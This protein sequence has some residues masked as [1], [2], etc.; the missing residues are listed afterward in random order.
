MKIVTVLRT[1]ETYNRKY[2]EML[3][4]QCQQFA[5]GIE[6]ICISDD[7]LVPG[8][9]KMQHDWPRW[10]PKIE[11]FKIP[12]PVLYL[13]LDTTLVKDI[14]NV[15]EAANNYSFVGVRDFYKDKRMVK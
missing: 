2:V 8:Y 15:I 7:P 14:R 5:P 10:W 9:S 13:D 11:M 1:S 6:F 3:H 12:G 4:S